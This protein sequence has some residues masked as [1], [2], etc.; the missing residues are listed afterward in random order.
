MNNIKEVRKRNNTF[1][2]ELDHSSRDHFWSHYYPQWENETFDVFDRYVKPNSIVIDIGAWI[3]PTVLYNSSLGADV[4]AVE[5][6]KGSLFCL[7]NNIHLNQFNVTVIEKA[8]YKDNMGVYFGENLFRDDGMNASTSQ[9]V[10]ESSNKQKY[11]TETITFSEIV[12]KYVSSNVSEEDKPISL[13]KVDIEGGEEHI[14]REVLEYSFKNRIPAYISFH[15]SWWSK[16]GRENFQNN[17]KSLFSS[18]GQDI[19]K[20][21]KDPFV[22][23]LFI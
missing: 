16:E 6:D 15:L 9:I 23:L 17:Y 11:K 7:K 5:A 4:I 12:N 10:S 19:E 1:Y 21:V 13:I 22:S 3:G 18:Y 14:L 20:V 2:V 8:I